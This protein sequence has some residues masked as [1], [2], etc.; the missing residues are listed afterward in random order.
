MT[1][2]N[3]AV[4]TLLEHRASG[5]RLIVLT[6]YETFPQKE[7]H[8]RVEHPNFYWLQEDYIREMATQH[9]FAWT[10]WRPPAIIGPRIPRPAS[11]F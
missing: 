7:R 2:D 3:I 8:P 1:K 5:A 11:G 10:V 9:G 4:V 6:N